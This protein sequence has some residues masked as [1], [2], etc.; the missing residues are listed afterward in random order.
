MADPDPGTGTGNQNQDRRSGGPSGRQPTLKLHRFDG[1]PPGE[2]RL[3]ERLVG[4]RLDR[5]LLYRAV[6]RH[7]TNRRQGTASTKTRSEVA[8]TG[9]K[10]WRQKG[11]GRARAGSFQSP[12]WRGGGVTFGPKPKAYRYEMPKKMRRKALRMA[13]SAVFREGRLHVV[14]RLAFQAPKTKEGL[15]LLERLQL[16]EA[17]VLVVCSA[18]ENTRAVK[19]SFT[20][21]PRVKCLPSENLTVYDLLDYEALLITQGALEELRERV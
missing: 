5:D 2:I 19:K 21:L 7:L 1:D 14:D 4:E 17:K 12:L 9:R 13:L 6:Q 3:D 15:K 8:G 18:A 10:P 16:G 20:N 11:T